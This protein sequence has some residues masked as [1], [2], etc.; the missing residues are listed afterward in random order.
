[1]ERLSHVPDGFHYRKDVRSFLAGRSVPKVTKVSAHTLAGV[2]HRGKAVGKVVAAGRGCGL[3]RVLPGLGRCAAKGI[4]S[5]IAYDRGGMLGKDKGGI[6][7][8]S[9]NTGGGVTG[10]LGTHNYRIAVCPTRAST[11]RVLKTGPSNVVL[12]GK[13]KSPGRYATVV[14]RLGGLCTDSMPVFTVY[15]NRRLV[16]LTGKTSARGVG[17]KRHNKGRPIGSLSA[18]H[19]CVSSRGRKC[20]MSASA[21]SPGITGP[22]FIGIG[23]KAGRNLRCIKGGVF[24]IRFRPRTY[25]KPRS[26][27]C[28]FSHFVRVVKKGRWYRRVGASGGC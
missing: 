2:L 12:D 7:L 24:A 11:R 19:I 14:R 27:S 25:P 13:P 6:T 28:L 16:T 1:M 4:I 8:V 20:I 22:T 26:S 17:C 3:S 21:L 10:S 18:N 23:S 9:F 15:L 5:G